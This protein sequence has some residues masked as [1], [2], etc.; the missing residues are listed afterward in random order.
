MINHSTTRIAAAIV[1]V[2][3]LAI[4]TQLNKDESGDGAATPPL[5]PQSPQFQILRRKGELSLSGHTASRQHEQDL[6][7]VAATSYSASSL[8]RNFRPLGTVPRYWHDVTVQVLAVLADAVSAQAD[9]TIDAIVIRGVSFDDADLKIRLHA[10]QQ[11]L[12][13]RISVSVDT[14]SVDARVNVPNVCERVLATFDTGPINFAESSSEFRSSAYPRLDRLIAVANACEDS[15]ISIT[16][17]TDASGDPGWNQYLSLNRANAVGDYMVEGGVDASRLLIIG[18]GSSV[19]VADD[20][21][22]YG[23]SLNRRIEISFLNNG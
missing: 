12:P 8:V 4:T 22:R 14:L 19:P 10:L 17:H 5:S 3:G 6:L 23:R 20:S 13:G 16:G 11:T 9:V 7:Q 18:A 2:G 15:D 1:L 21:T